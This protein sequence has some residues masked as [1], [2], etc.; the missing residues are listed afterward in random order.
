MRG[1]HPSQVAPL[2]GEARERFFIS[3]PFGD[4]L[5]SGDAVFLGG[6]F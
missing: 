4:L 6:G 3:F 2:S 5:I 1:V